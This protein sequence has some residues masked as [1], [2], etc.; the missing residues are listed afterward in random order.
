MNN[1]IRHP[2]V[3]A[4]IASITRKASTVR[5]ASQTFGVTLREALMIH[6][7]ANVTNSP[8]YLIES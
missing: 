5:S 1:R 4:M 3:F 8:C 7:L 6:I 2:A